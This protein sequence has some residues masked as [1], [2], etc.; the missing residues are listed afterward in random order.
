MYYVYILKSHKNKDIYV[1][2][3][4]DLRTRLAFHNSGKVKSTKAYTPW[5]LIY[6]EA[7]R[8]KTDSTKREKELKIHAAKE[9]LRQRLQNSLLF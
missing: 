2:R 1:G 4:S 3:S 5:T 6:Y 8:S 9:A 7:Y